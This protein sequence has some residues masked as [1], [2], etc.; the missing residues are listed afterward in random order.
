MLNNKIISIHESSLNE[1]FGEISNIQSEEEER[2]DRLG[3][4]AKLRSIINTLFPGFNQTL[5]RRKAMKYYT[6][7][8]TE[9]RVINVID[10]ISKYIN[11]NV[12]GI[13]RVNKS[14]GTIEAVFPNGVTIHIRDR[15]NLY[16]VGN[17]EL[18]C[19]TI[20][21]PARGT[22]SI[23]VYEGTPNSKTFALW[24]TIARAGRESVDKSEKKPVTTRV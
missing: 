17:D 3:F 5:T 20:T 9:A 2:S 13:D 24:G 16:L 10:K 4:G 11:G 22:I 7:P 15:D 6:S 8:A 1:I 23:P 21:W 18:K 12:F 14:M 19:I